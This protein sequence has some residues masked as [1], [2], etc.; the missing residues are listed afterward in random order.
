MSERR[1]LRYSGGGSDKFWTIEL[2]GAS[3]SVHFGRVGTNGQRKSK[4]FDSEE[5]ARASFAQL[6]AQKLKKGYAEA[7]GS[8][9]A[10]A[11]SAPASSAVKSAAAKKKV[12]T[13]KATKQKASKRLVEGIDLPKEAAFLALWRDP[14]PLPRGKAKAFDRDKLLGRLRKWGSNTFLTSDS[15][16]A[17]RLPSAMSRGE[18][19]LYLRALHMIQ[20][21]GYQVNAEVAADRLEALDEWDL[22]L[23][24]IL[25]MWPAETHQHAYWPDPGRATPVLRVMSQLLDAEQLFDWI[26]ARLETVGHWDGSPQV[27]VG[28]VQL[29]VAYATG[30]L[31]YLSREERRALLAKLEPLELPDGATMV[32]NRHGGVVPWGRFCFAA[33]LGHV[34]ATRA[35]V[36]L[37]SDRALDP[38]TPDAASAGSVFVGGVGGAAASLEVAERLDFYPESEHAMRAWLANTGLDGLE[39]A[40]EAVLRTGYPGD[41]MRALLDVESPRFVPHLLAIREAKSGLAKGVARWAKKRPR[42]WA[43]GLLRALAGEQAA[44]AREELIDLARAQPE[45]L[46]ELLADESLDPGLRAQGQAILSGNAEQAE[47]SSDLPEALADAFAAVQGLGKAKAAAGAPW[48]RARTLAPLA[49]AGEELSEA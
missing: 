48:L 38:S 35:L 11:P 22:D 10:P 24:E 46:S 47:I 32:L 2:E 13:K 28:I 37:W 23:D 29:L 20:T 12:T 19:S 31:P 5:E 1:E 4:D 14:E 27:T 6:I 7:G 26:R 40:R 9:P 39:R 49:V 16:W 25:A 3:H 44:A 30:V 21:G 45:V 33:L 34:E 43:E 15:A 36:A 17:K 41:L 8:A 42:A 18:A